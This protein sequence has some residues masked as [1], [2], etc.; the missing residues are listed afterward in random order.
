MGRIPEEVIE[1]VRDRV[2]IV[3]LVGRFVSLK[4]AGRNHKGLCPFHDEKT[5]SFVVTPDRGT[6]KCFGCGEGGNAFGFL[7]QLENLSFPEAVRALAGEHGIEVPES[8]GGDTS[9]TKPV[10]EANSI[11]QATY[12]AALA[13]PGNEG[14]RYLEQRGID[15]DLIESFEIGFA[16][17]AWETVSDE[18]RRARIPGEVGEKA[19]LLKEGRRGGHYDMLRGRVTFPIRDVRGRV[20]GFGGRSLSSDQEPKY[21]NTPESPVF[22]KRRSFFGMPGALEPIRREERAVVVEGYFDLVALHRAGIKS[23]VATCGT[24][25]TSDHARE[26]RR[27]TRKVVLLFDGDEAGQKAMMRGLEVLLPA[28]LRVHAAVL[29]PGEDPEDFLVREG[30]EALR[31]LVDDAPEALEIVMRRVVS[32]GVASPAEK[33][34]AVASVAPLLVHI[35]SPVE[36]GAW[37]ERLALFVGA[38]PEDVRAAVRTQRS[39]GN[40]Q[41][42]LPVGPRFEPAEVRKLQQLARSLVEHPHLAARFEAE[43]LADVRGMPVIELIHRL[44]GAADTDRRVDLEEISEG[45]SSD[46]RS[47]LYA[48]ASADH[49]LDEDV[50]AQTVDDTNRWLASREAQSQQRDLTAKLRTGGDDA[51]EIL[52]AK[53]AAAT[54]PPAA[55]RH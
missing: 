4:P 17:D 37:E 2:D 35:S 36:R 24:A 11:A 9:G 6:Y 54:P 43:P 52:R 28:E 50:A 51:I 46:A 45:I 5:P 31:K 21:L 40:A 3:D 55:R 18:L 8:G 48:L 44:L 34:D 33:A 42:A 25:V 19:G 16:P 1:Q 26:L 27:R 32:Q 39:G 53:L 29:P 41:E 23:G 47:L 10:F 49:P 12:R 15:A 38:N 22:Q 14:A 13:K 20:I 30:A 7:M